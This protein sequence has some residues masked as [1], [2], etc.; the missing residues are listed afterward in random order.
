MNAIRNVT[1]PDIGDFKD[2]PIVEILVKP[3]DLVTKDAPLVMLES[4]KATL[5]VP[6]PGNG[7]VKELKVALGTRVSKGSLL[8]T[9]DEASGEGG[10]GIARSGCRPVARNCG[11]VRP[12]S[13][14]NHSIGGSLR[15][16]RV[17]SGQLAAARGASHRSWISHRSGAWH[18]NLAS[19]SVL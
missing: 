14:P 19:T 3:G 1:V 18:G 12:G 9:L 4:D 8:L 16:N 13:P 6:S 11:R 5:D 15:D 10:R 17:P 2:V 7:I